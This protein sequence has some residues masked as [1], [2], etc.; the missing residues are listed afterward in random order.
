MGVDLRSSGG[1][2]R[3]L[4]MDFKACRLGHPDFEIFEDFFASN[5]IKLHLLPKNVFDK[6]LYIAWKH[7]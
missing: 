2:L 3:I 5:L 4:L 7:I 6:Y 1:H